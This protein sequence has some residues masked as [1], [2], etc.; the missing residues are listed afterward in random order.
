LSLLDIR[1]YDLILLDL[2]LFDVEGVASVAALQD[3][4]ERTPII[5][6]TGADDLQLK[7]E[8]LM[9]GAKNYWVKG[10]EY[11]IFFGFI[12]EQVLNTQL[13]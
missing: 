4:V 9:C 2:D 11:S 10:K 5:V 1:P 12:V 6:H 13:R 7:K 8:A 3:H